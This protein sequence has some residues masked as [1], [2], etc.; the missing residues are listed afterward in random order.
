MENA[1]GFSGRTGGV[2]D[3]Q[4]VFGIEGFGVVGGGG[5][6]GEVVPPKVTAFFHFDVLSGALED[7]DGFDIFGFF[8]GGIDIVF[9]GD[10]FATAPAAVGGDDEFGAGVFEP[11][12]DGVGG[13]PAKDDRMHG[14]D[15]GAGEH[16]NGGLGNHRHVDEDAVARA[17]AAGGEGIGE[18]ADF[19]VELGVG[20]HAA[21][22]RFTFEDD[23]RFIFS[24]AGGVAVEA[25]FGDVEFTANEPF[26]IG[27]IPF[28]GFF[29]RLLP[30]EFF[31]FAGPEFFRVFDGGI[32]QA[33]VFGHAG[34]AGFFGKCFA[35]FV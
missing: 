24:R 7:D 21:V 35:R 16:G 30:G 29:P 3:E 32:P 17:N 14:A 19:A 22:A 15:A 1:F 26:G 28:E 34:Y 25:A 10:G 13:K 31:G 11:V 23:G 4:R 5:F 33:F 12:G 27:G 9:E 20:E 8:Q 6:G 2:E 18:L